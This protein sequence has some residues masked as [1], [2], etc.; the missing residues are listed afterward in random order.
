MRITD[1][2]R[3]QTGWQKPWYYGFSYT[4]FDRNETYYYWIPIN[5]LVKWTRTFWRWLH[6]P[7]IKLDRDEL[8][9]KAGYEMGFKQGVKTGTVYGISD[10][11]QR[12]LDNYQKLKEKHHVK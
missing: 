10:E 5:I 4:A 3:I 12:V 11:K 9:F 6:F 8:A 2:H 1:D 7:R